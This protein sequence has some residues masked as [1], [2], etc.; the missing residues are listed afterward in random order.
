M[1]KAIFRTLAF[2]LLLGAPLGAQAVEKLTFA[3]AYETSEAF[4]KWAVWAADQV[5]ARTDGRYEID[6]FPASQL[7]SQQE[8]AEG[9]DLGT[10]DMGYVGPSF[11]AA[12]YPPIQIHLAAFLWKDYDHFS[13]YQGSAIQKQVVSG[14][15]NASGNEILSLTYYGQRHTTSNKEI[16]T[17][18]DMVGLK[19]RVPPV[20][21]YEIF[22]RAVGAAPTPIAFAE[23]YLAL[24]QGVVEAQ[25]NPLPTILA[26][27]F[28]EV[29][30]YI[31][32]TAHMT[33]GFYTVV[34][35]HL[36]D[37]MS[38]ADQ[39]IFNEVYF[40]AAQKCG[41]DIRSSE[42][43]LAGKFREQGITVNE[44]DRELFKA[45][46]L[47]SLYDSSLPWSREQIDEILALA[48]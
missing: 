46:A 33:D 9:I 6:V 28:Y 3:H 4:H 10:I 25:E 29:Q 7:G 22:P 2:A 30:Q 14:Y 32:L 45:K 1:N 43:E 47:P 44:V 19:M 20:Q 17:P 5:K 42:L 34:G 24:Q 39:K 11:L 31:T 16:K 27:K 13:R 38:A 12:V 21:I 15:E 41:A 40:E 48:N 37:E 36:W 8:M 26:K 23:L 18:E 35:R